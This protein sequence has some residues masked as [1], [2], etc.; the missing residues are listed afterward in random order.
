[1]TN[2]RVEQ[3]T[4][5]ILKKNSKKEQII[6]RR[7]KN[8]WPQNWKNPANRQGKN[9]IE[10]LLP[11][12]LQCPLKSPSMLQDMSQKIGRHTI[13]YALHIYIKEINL[14]IESKTKK[15]IVQVLSI[16]KLIN[17]TVETNSPTFKIN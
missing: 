14:K 3:N 1:M 17:H 2:P 5:N 13:K 4:I 12:P 9:I 10:N 7:E 16:I 15:N 6:S 8:N 11:F